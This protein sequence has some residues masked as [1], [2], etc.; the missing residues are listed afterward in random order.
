MT[1]SERRNGGSRPSRRRR[2]LQTA[3]AVAVVVAIF[4]AAIPRIAS[5]GS[6]WRVLSGLTGF[7]LALVAGAAAA[8]I[9]TYWIQSVAA[10]PRLTLGQAAVQT[11]T[12]TTVA[13]TVPGGGAV[14]VGLGYAMFRSWGFSDGEIG[15]FVLITGIWNTLIKFALPIVALGLLALEGGASSKIAW[16]AV[17]GLLALV[18]AVAILALVLWKRSLAER[19]G[20]AI[21]RPV[22]WVRRRVGKD[23]VDGER[24]AVD[25]R[26]RTVD[27]LHDRWLALSAATVVSHVSLFLVLLAALRVTGVS[28]AEVTWIEAL[29]VF[30][31]ARLVTAL[32]VTP[33]GVGVIELSYIGGLVYAGGDR[34][35]VAAAVLLFRGFTYV[36]QI[37]LGAIT[38]P[39]WQRRTSWR[40]SSRSGG[41]G[42]TKA[43]AR[44]RRSRTGAASR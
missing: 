7:Q 14:A 33:G 1:T 28:Q 37:P 17:V 16:A 31:F 13:N 21:A 12:T 43:P 29:G 44:R 32:P 9:A 11:Q 3:I 27:L 24:A 22:S 20:R 4:A 25:F 41:S 42:S 19:I 15:L 36:L 5:Y 39:I 10:M 34:A 30:A 35:A 38:Y 23:H 40:R 26:D 18:V 6:I 2:V 8:N